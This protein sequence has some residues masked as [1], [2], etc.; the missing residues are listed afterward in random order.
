MRL[1]S[2]RVTARHCRRPQPQAV[3]AGM[4]AVVGQRCTRREAFLVAGPRAH[5]YVYSAFLSAWRNEQALSN[6][7]VKKQ[8]NTKS[9]T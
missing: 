6:V 3:R 9:L 4:R 7:N 1:V 8:I 2:P 5:A